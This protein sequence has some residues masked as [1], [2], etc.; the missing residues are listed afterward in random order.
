MRGR[1]R[2]DEQL[3]M[4]IVDV[5]SVKFP[6]NNG[7]VHMLSFAHLL[8]DCAIKIMLFDPIDNQ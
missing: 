3:R 7:S 1:G 6:S 8:N 4:I 2:E 5:L